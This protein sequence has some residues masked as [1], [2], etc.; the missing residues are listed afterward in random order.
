MARNIFKSAAQALFRKPTVEDTANRK[1]D[2][3]NHEIEVYTSYIDE[4][5]AEQLDR[6]AYNDGVAFALR[7][8]IVPAP[9][10]RLQSSRERRAVTHTL[11]PLHGAYWFDWTYQITLFGEPAG[12]VNNFLEDLMKEL[13]NYQPE[14]HG[15]GA[16]VTEV[17]PT[18]LG[19]LAVVHFSGKEFYRPTA[20]VIPSMHAVEL[21]NELRSTD[22]ILKM[23]E[24]A[25]LTGAPLEFG[26][27]AKRDKLSSDEPVAYTKRVNVLST[28]ER[29]FTAKHA[30]GVRR[31]NFAKVKW[32]ITE[33]YMRRPVQHELKLTL[34][35]TSVSGDMANLRLEV[36][37]DRAR[38]VNE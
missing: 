6:R 16:S 15:A 1:L 33:G 23:V 7:N 22:N 38:S 18:I 27:L 24:L 25:K 3:I 11:S 30:R 5:A 2:S 8:A 35:G 20:N 37:L 34:H 13:Q 21:R 31:Y 36:T 26:Y 19:R 29:G 14:K 10:Q 12:V 4:L 28:D 9:P 32:A 17:I